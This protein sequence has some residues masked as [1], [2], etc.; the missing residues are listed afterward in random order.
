MARHL[1]ETF[2]IATAVGR[3]ETTAQDRSTL[4]TGLMAQ[5]TAIAAV[6][7]GLGL[8]TLLMFM[9][10]GSAPERLQQDAELA[11]LVRT[12][13]SIKGLILAIATAMVVWRLGRPVSASRLLGYGAALASSGAALAWMWSLNAIPVTAFLFYGGLVACYLIASRDGQLLGGRITS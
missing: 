13:V 7:G 6:V 11:G 10:A 3:G 12:M 2:S 1:S 9:L 4:N 5:A 8:G